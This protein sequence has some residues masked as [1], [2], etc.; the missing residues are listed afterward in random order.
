MRR[1]AGVDP[2]IRRVGHQVY[3]RSTGSY[4]YAVKLT[5]PEYAGEE[6]DE[7]DVPLAP[8]GPSGAYFN[9]FLNRVRK[10]D[11]CRGHSR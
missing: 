1:T 6:G 7:A 9:G 8:G 5:K 3:Q 2:R 11:S 4:E 10:F